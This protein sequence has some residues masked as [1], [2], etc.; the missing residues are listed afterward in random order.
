MKLS[1]L[2]TVSLSLAFCWLLLSA[3]GDG[4]RPSYHQG[5]A[6]HAGE[7]LYPS[8]WQGLVGAWVPALGPTGTAILRDV[9]GRNNHGTMVSIPGTAWSIVGVQVGL[10]P[11]E[12]T[13]RLVT[14]WVLDFVG[15]T[16]YIQTTASPLKDNDNVTIISIVRTDDTNALQL[17]WWEGDVLGN[18]GGAER[19]I[20]F[21]VG[22][23]GTGSVGRVSVAG[24]SNSTD[25]VKSVTTAN[26]A[27]FIHWTVRMEGLSGTTAT[28]TIF[29]NGVL[30]G[31]ILDSNADAS[32]SQGSFD[33]DFRIGRPGTDTRTWNGQVAD[34]RVY[35]RLLTNSE[36]ALDADNFLAPFQLRQFRNLVKAPAA[37][38]AAAVPERA[39]MGVGT[40]II[41]RLE[42]KRRSYPCGEAPC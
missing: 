34:I 20:H 32:L 13:P 19:E 28:A 8:L 16:D 7:S 29:R 3:F 41:E 11:T 1:K 38:P 30:A 35:D 24:E 5:Y 27:D 10:D 26:T 40:K 18:G 17:L 25:L 14:S 15:T 21:G 37:A 31:L 23:P 6:R 36:I 33:T 9:S 2:F 12:T 39:K 4:P 42:W 22:E